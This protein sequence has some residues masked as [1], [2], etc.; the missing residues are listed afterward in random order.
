MSTFTVHLLDRLLTRVHPAVLVLVAMISVGCSPAPPGRPVEQSIATTP[1]PVAAPPKFPATPTVASYDAADARV[2]DGSET[3]QIQWPV[4]SGTSESVAVK[5][6]TPSQQLRWS[7]DYPLATINDLAWSPDGELLAVGG[8]THDSDKQLF[9]SPTRLYTEDGTV[10]AELTTDAV[11]YAGQ[12]GSISDLEWSSD[13][14]V[15][16]TAGGPNMS[17]TLF[18][19]SGQ[20][21]LELADVAISVHAVRWSPDGRFFVLVTGDRDLYLYD[22]AGNQIDVASPAGSTIDSVMWHPDG[23]QLACTD[24]LG[25]MLWGLRADSSNE[26]SAGA[27][28]LVPLVRV[29]LPLGEDQWATTLEWNR[30]GTRLAVGAFGT[31]DVWLIDQEGTPLATLRGHTESVWR[32]RFSSEGILATTSS[33]ATTRLWDPDGKPIAVLVS[34]TPE[35]DI[36]IDV[37]SWSPDGKLLAVA[38]PDPLIRIYSSDAVPLANLRGHTGTIQAISWHPHERKLASADDDELTCVWDLPALPH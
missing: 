10:A 31:G 23:T 14:R 9:R 22:A 13:G 7:A 26:E 38:S 27:V 3:P 36:L 30:D 4:A 2:I 21:K 29:T 24:P 16:A 18:Y 8:M 34:A 33:D 1:Q 20:Q 12:D 5:Q 19:P 37:A 17:A 6:V 32:T 15:M 35:E 11:R 25:V 28:S